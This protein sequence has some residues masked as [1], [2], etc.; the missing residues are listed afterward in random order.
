[1]L[2]MLGKAGIVLN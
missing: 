2:A 1:M